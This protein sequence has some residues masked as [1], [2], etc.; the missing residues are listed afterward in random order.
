MWLTG[1]KC[2]C[3]AQELGGRSPPTSV[4]RSSTHFS[5]LGEDL[6]SGI[7]CRQ[8]SAPGETWGW[9][10]KKLCQMNNTGEARALVTPVPTLQGPCNLSQKWRGTL[11]FLPDLEIRPSSIAANPVKSREAS[12]SSIVSLTS[13]RH[14]EKLPEVTGTS[15]GNPGFPA[16]TRERPQASFFTMMTSPAAAGPRLRAGTA[17]R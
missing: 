2:P 16:A 17:A 8:R 5:T 13:Q 6:R 9:G 11:R 10:W 15:R 12:P 3:G 7:W 14:P 1:L 4:C